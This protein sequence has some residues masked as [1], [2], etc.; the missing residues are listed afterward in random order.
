MWLWTK[1]PSF[2]FYTKS[3]GAYTG[4]LYKFLGK[5][6]SLG[7]KWFWDRFDRDFLSFYVVHGKQH[8]TLAS[9]V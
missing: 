8:T 1:K 7:K 5:T 2:F 3:L 6:L 9:V 4:F